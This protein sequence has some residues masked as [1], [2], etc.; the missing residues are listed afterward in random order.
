M[1]SLAPRQVILYATGMRKYMASIKKG[2][3][4]SYTMDTFCRLQWTYISYI[5]NRLF[6]RLFL[7]Q[8][9]RMCQ[10]NRRLPYNLARRKRL[11]WFRISYSSKT[12]NICELTLIEY[13]G[14]YNWGFITSRSS[15]KYVCYVMLPVSV[16]AMVI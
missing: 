15:D 5:H 4:R 9:R 14:N 13:E 12:E 6:F 1:R 3:L 2:K 7:H 16:T 8:S 10:T 11:P